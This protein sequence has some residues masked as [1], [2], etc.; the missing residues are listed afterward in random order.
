MRGERESG[1]PLPVY[2]TDPLAVISTPECCY[3]TEC[4]DECDEDDEQIHGVFLLSF[5]LCELSSSTS[6]F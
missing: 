6:G 4:N 3:Q 5:Y 2:A 1:P